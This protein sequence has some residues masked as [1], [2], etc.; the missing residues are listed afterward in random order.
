MSRRRLAVA[1][2]A[3]AAV[4]VV[5]SATAAPPTERGPIA[6]AMWPKPAQLDGTVA[7]YAGRGGI[8][9]AMRPESAQRRGD[10]PRASGR[11]ALREA[12][13]LTALGPRPAG[14]RAERRAHARVKRAFGRAGLRVA[15]QPFAVPGHGRS[16][17]V[18][19]T[20]DAPR[21]DCL[22]IAMA[23]IDTTAPG[24]GANDNASGVG[25]VVAIAARLRRIAPRCDVW[26]VATGAEERIFTGQGDHLG[27]LAL[28]RRARARG[29]KRRLRFALSLDEVGRDRPFWLRSP[30]AAPRPRVERALL[31]AGL[32]HEVRY[33]PG[34]QELRPEALLVA[35]SQPGGVVVWGLADDLTTAY[36]ALRR[37]GYEGLVY[38]R[39]ALLQPGSPALPWPQLINARFALPP[40]AV[41]SG[42]GTAPA[43]PYEPR[44]G[45]GGAA[46]ACAAAGRVDAE[47]LARVPG[48]SANAVATAPFLAALDLA[49][50]GLEQLIALQIPASEPPVLR[51]ALR[52][53]MVGRPARCTG[54]GLV[55]LRDGSVSA[56]E[57]G[58]LAVGAATRSGLAPLR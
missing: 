51:Q 33:P 38:G 25:V 52:D 53:A 50:A 26:L 47:R 16:R 46:G 22:K 24:P 17:N 3:I 34:V 6:V 29:A 5:A 39:T 56:I 37:R 14:S 1:A 27:A 21:R 32:T 57:P 13:R 10:P 9:A 41:P 55:D 54:A 20:L 30:A 7:T 35:S 15:V 28:A 40:A 11:V 58:G 2:L 44:P 18:I 49:A 23:H 4:A 8:A 12:R 45:T 36:A 42:G 31:R 48:A 19:G 43:D